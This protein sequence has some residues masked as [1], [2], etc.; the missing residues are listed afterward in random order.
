M[1]LWQQT[2]QPVISF[3]TLSTSSQCRPITACSSCQKQHIMS[4]GLRPMRSCSINYITNRKSKADD[5]MKFRPS[6]WTD[7][8]KKM[9]AHTELDCPKT[10][11]RC[12]AKWDWVNTWIHLVLSMSWGIFYQLKKSYSVV[13]NTK[14]GSSQNLASG[15]AT[16]NLFATSFPWLFWILL[17]N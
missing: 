1:W 17:S 16:L 14:S 5:S 7:I 12:A 3:H 2:S 4:T 9:L 10:V 6:F 11:T 8:A 13:C 15:G